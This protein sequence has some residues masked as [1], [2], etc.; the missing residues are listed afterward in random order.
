MRKFFTPPKDDAITRFRL[1]KDGR[2]TGGYKLILT[3]N[4]V[5][6]GIMT[7]EKQSQL[8]DYAE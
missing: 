1:T 2:L 7:L 8:N 5:R 3:G 4:K 6:R